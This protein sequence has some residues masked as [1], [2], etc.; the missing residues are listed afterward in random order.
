MRAGRLRRR[1]QLQSATETRDAHGQPV[2]T[3]STQATVW[4]S[5]E[6]AHGREYIQARQVA[7]ENLWRVMIRYRS[8]V[9][10]DWR[11]VYGA[12]TLEIESVINPDEDDRLLQIYCKEFR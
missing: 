12:K 5:V 8:D 4:A 10:S 6:P 9:T 1:I 7:Q 3:W 2:K 11:I